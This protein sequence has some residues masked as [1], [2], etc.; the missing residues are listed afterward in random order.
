MRLVKLSF[1]LIFLV[2]CTVVPPKTVHPMMEDSSFCNVDA[3]CTCGGIDSK[4]D[5]CF[6]GNKLYASK[7]VD[8]SRSCPDFCT[9]IAAHLE[10]K[11]VSHVCKN[12]PRE[13]WN[14]PVACTEEAK[15]CPDGSAVGRTGPNCEFAPCPVPKL[16]SADLHWQCEDGSW[17]VS[18]ENCF[19]NK[20]ISKDDCQLLEVSFTP[21][22][23]YKIATPKSVHKAP[24]FSAKKCD[25]LGRCSI[26]SPECAAPESLPVIT[27]VACESNRCITL[28]KDVRC[29]SDADCVPADCCHA[30]A[31]VS[32]SQAPQCAG[33]MCTMEC[34]GGTLDCGGSCGCKEGKCSAVLT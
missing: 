8:F 18:P 21:C 33:M 15:L 9:G 10:T 6:V 24:V 32:K 12:V 11:C 26:M 31:C 30:I 17:S 22:S 14:K 27:D 16:G 25:A 28:P 19:E 1:F 4:T 29:S 23:P 2:A 5:N 3:D 7:Y 13:G 34:R 20:C